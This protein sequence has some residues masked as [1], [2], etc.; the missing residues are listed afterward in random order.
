MTSLEELIQMKMLGVYNKTLSFDLFYPRNGGNI[1]KVEIG[2][3][4]VRASDSILIEYDFDRDG[5]SIKQVSKFQREEDDEEYDPDW[6]EVVF[7]QA[8][9]REVK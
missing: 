3:S 7:I 2:L 5:W 9:G 1:D 8:W 6:Q 4:D